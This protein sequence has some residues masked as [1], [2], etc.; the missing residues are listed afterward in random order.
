MPA[1]V[2]MTVNMLWCVQAGVEQA[3]KE[4]TADCAMRREPFATM[5]IDVF[6]WWTMLADAESNGMLSGC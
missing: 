4:E 2:H 3:S 1:E 5:G 6:G